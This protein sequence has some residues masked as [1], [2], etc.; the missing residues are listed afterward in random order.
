M[1]FAE[2]ALDPRLLSNLQQL[3]YTQPTPIQQQ[4]IAPILA[5]R[6]LLAGA[7]TGTG[8]TAAFVLP[9]LQRL[10]TTAAATTP[11]HALVLVPTRELALQVHQSVERY[12]AG[13]G[14]R[15]ALV[16]GGVSIAAPAEV[17]QAGVELVIAT[18][19]R[20]LDHLRQGVVS[21]SGVEVLVLDEADRMLLDRGRLRI[22][23]LLQVAEQARI[24]G[25]F[26]KGHGG[27]LGAGNGI[28]P[29][30]AGGAPW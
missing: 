28:R 12:G 30:A 27:H 1:S 22:T 6:D 9:I 29:G 3:G 14:L 10:L 23:E 18:P 19:G 26:G 2:F 20:L 15:A 7:Q 17:L 21:L 13:T 4:A 16:Y 11:V 25:K 24:E 5:G 8:K